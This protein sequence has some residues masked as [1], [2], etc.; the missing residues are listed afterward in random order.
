VITLGVIPLARLIRSLAADPD[1][2]ERRWRLTWSSAGMT[3][4]VVAVLFVM[5][6]PYSSIAEAV[7]VVPEKR[8]VR[9]AAEGFLLNLVAEPGAQVAAGA[10]LAVIVDPSVE[11]EVKVLRAQVAAL[12][13]RL[14]AVQFTNR[15]EANL[16]RA[17]MRSV[18]E[19]LA[20]MSERMVEQT[21]LAGADGRFL[22]PMASDLPGR[23]FQRGAIIGYVHDA[24]E[25]IIR[26]VVEQAGMGAIARGVRDV[27]VWEAGYET[28]PSPGIV[29]RI[30][31]GGGNE[32]P[33][34]ALAVD[35]G[36]TITL[37]PRSPDKLRTTANLFQID[38]EMQRN[39]PANFIGKRYYVR[40]EHQPR[41][42]GLQFYDVLRQAMLQRFGV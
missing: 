41:P 19:E 28:S 4:A 20:R 6:A 8:Q 11:S 35:G 23:F 34:K 25:V 10:R 26:A 22:V 24:N 42:L 5:P 38:L 31:P 32:L 3:A 40:F 17:E 30:A 13:A 21:V 9:A 37:D 7:A 18:K 1:L 12:E 36:G 14:A 15:V 29:R 33:N 2:R 39:T 16:I 27:T